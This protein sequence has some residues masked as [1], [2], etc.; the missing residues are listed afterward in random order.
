MR[1]DDIVLSTWRMLVVEP[2]K[3]STWV[4]CR[5]I[6]AFPDDWLRSTGQVAKSTRY[7]CSVGLGHER[8]CDETYGLGVH[9]AGINTCAQM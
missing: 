5:R 7:V 6:G 1:I 2:R 8:C 9:E 3:M 4:N